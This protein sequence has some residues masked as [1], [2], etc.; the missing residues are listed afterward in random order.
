M[1]TIR[2]DGHCDVVMLV[3][4]DVATL[5]PMEIWESPFATVVARL[6]EPGSRSRN[7]R[8]ALAVS[9][10]KRLGMLVWTAEQAPN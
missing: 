3:L 5:D 8:G 1:G 10:F 4:L 6:A 2:P 7:E 9:D